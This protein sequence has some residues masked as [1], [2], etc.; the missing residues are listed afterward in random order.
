MCCGKEDMCLVV[1]LVYAIYGTNEIKYN[2][3]L[4]PTCLT[5]NIFSDEHLQRTFSRTSLINQ[6]YFRCK[7]ILPS[8]NLQSPA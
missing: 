4:N 8:D 6:S 7:T 2:H 5:V 1:K 3:E